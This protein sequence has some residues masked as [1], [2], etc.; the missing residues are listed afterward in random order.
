MNK[1]LGFVFAVFFLIMSNLCIAQVENPY[2]DFNP[3]SMKN[4]K[5]YAKNFNPSNFDHK[6][7]YACMQDMVNVARAQ[8]SFAPAMK[9]DISLDS[10][11]VMQA[12]YQALTE[13][14]SVENLPPYRTTE[15][16]LRKFR[17]TDRGTEL[18]SKA[19]ATLGE[20]EYSYYDVCLELL[21]PVLKNVK[22]AE[23]LLDRKYSYLGFG[24]AFD[25]YMKSVYCSFI[26]A[27][28]RTFNY[29][30]PNAITRDLPYTKT[31]LGLQPFDA[32][33]C[34]RCMTDLAVETLSE[35]ISIKDGVVYFTH[36]N[37]KE[38]RR[39]IGKEGDAIVLD[40]VQHSQYP[41][42]KSNDVDNDRPN[43]GFMT[44]TITYQ[45]MLD[46]NQITDKKSTKLIAPIAAIPEEIPDNAEIDVNIIIIKDGKYVCRDILKKNVEYKNSDY[47]E[48]MFFLNDVTTI[49]PT[50]EWV[51]VAED[52]VLKIKIPFED[53]KY[54]LTVNDITPYIESLDEPAYR[55]NKIVITAYNSLELT[56]DAAAKKLQ[57]KRAKS[58]AASLKAKYPSAN[59]TVE[60]K[61]ADTW[62][63]FKKDLVYSEEYYDLTIMTMEDAIA[64]LRRDKD[65]IAKILEADYLKKHRFAEIQMDVTYR[66]DG[67][68]KQEFSVFKLNKSIASK[69]LPLAVAIQQY[70]AKQIE[71]KEFSRKAVLQ[72]EIPNKKEYQPLLMNKFYIQNIVDGKITD[73]NAADMLEVCKLNLTNNFALY[74]QVMC[75]VAGRAAFASIADIT[76]RQAAIDKLYTIAILPKEEVNNLNLEFQFQIIDYLNTIPA[77]M[78]TATLLTAT[79]LKIKEIRNPKLSSWRNAYKLASVFVKHGD[80]VYAVDLM[81]P[82]L[83]SP[84]I[85][86]D[87]LFSYISI[88]AVRE[89]L[90]L[91]ANFSEAVKL[92]AEK[93]SA[94][95][96]GLFDKLPI[97]VFDNK[98]VK[99]IICKTCNK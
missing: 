86:L 91:S 71:S 64:T 66:I 81:E 56:N 95:L 14:K 26:L 61:Y 23:V 53:K 2:A 10:A 97:V 44:K 57:E 63:L 85:S 9:V 96:C 83:S 25:Q 59:F 20:A 92:A 39:I 8:Y 48:K 49:K 78:E 51:P 76:T 93:D 79:Y 70:I 54:E 38:L 22:T 30:K 62:Q 72:M 11:A 89:E 74:N 7:L 87:F 33:L 67:D 98:D 40:F 75:Q 99:T 47:T 82:F 12:D 68:Y 21:K 69:N 34:R 28:D 84:D 31:R 46:N 50:G 52:A 24:Y 3:E 94:R 1:K 88:A 17:F 37:S 32:Q 60:I 55:I 90:Y 15:Q 13:E 6:I 36:N 73:K 58:I 80:Y 43:H 35:C 29:G 65:K 27:N 19:K 18:V 41:C 4:V 42:G 45:Y 77:T 16:R 5:N